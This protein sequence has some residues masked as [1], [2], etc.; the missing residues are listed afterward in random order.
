M[1]FIVNKKSKTIIL[2][3]ALGM[4]VLFFFYY[5]NSLNFYGNFSI[6]VWQKDK[7]ISENTKLRG[8]S[9]F[10][11]EYNLGYQQ[12][13]WINNDGCY[14][15]IQIT[16][17]QPIISDSNRITVL[18]T[19]DD[20]HYSKEIRLSE[21]KGNRASITKVIIDEPFYKTSLKYF[22]FLIKK[23]SIRGNRLIIFLSFGI[24]VL[25]V[26][27]RRYKHNGMI[28]KALWGFLLISFLL[29]FVPLIVLNKTLTYTGF[30]LL[31]FVFSSILILLIFLSKKVKYLN[32]NMI[33]LFASFFTIIL[34][35]ELLLRLFGVNKSYS[36]KKEGFVRFISEQSQLNEYF[37]NRK[38]NHSFLLNMSG[39]F[40]YPRTTNSIGLSDIETTSKKA[41]N[42]YLIMALGD[43]FTEGDGADSDSTWMKFLERKIGKKDTVNYRFI[44]AGICGSDPVYEYK[45][46]VDKLIAYK[47]NLVICAYGYDLQEV[48]LRGGFE[49]FNTDNN[50]TPIISPS[51]E[52]LY[53][54]SY[55]SRLV[56]NEIHDLD[57]QLINS[58]QFE[59]ERQNAI[60]TINNVILMFKELSLK[61]DFKL[62]FVFY[63]L[64]HEVE[65]NKYD[66][67]NEV[68][69]FA[70]KNEIDVFPLLHYFSDIEKVDSAN[71]KEYYWKTDGH[72]NA[73]GYQAFGN[74][75]YWKLTNMGLLQ[76]NTIAK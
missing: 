46:F 30:W 6:Q 37:Y 4:I 25:I 40:S 60:R 41:E 17:T 12:G 24:F 3:F 52:F 54:I 23:Y 32:K 34:C 8:V 76:E 58:K 67:W 70:T 66:Y 65:G 20:I 62:L 42:D 2:A 33:L 38:P 49:R 56:I 16:F 48:I 61:N 71:V 53:S 43:S 13:K 19:K 39:E 7:N 72:Y 74:G 73:K 68:I 47:P 9:F 63:P 51:L 15:E 28:E 35:I 22:D 57:Y 64:K 55:I 44:N 14:K 50:K 10:N 31:F 27:F 36:E 26:F 75:V 5:L 29:A 11:R 18:F 21:I 59:S 1:N 69:R 45:L